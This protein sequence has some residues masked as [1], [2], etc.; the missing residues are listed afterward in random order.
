[1][2]SSSHSIA[3]KDHEHKW[4]VKRPRL[5]EAGKSTMTTRVGSRSS[6][7]TSSIALAP[8]SALDY[9]SNPCVAHL[10]IEFLTTRELGRWLIQTNK[11]MT[12]QVF[13][14]NDHWRILC[15][16]R[17]EQDRAALAKIRQYTGLSDEAIFRSFAYSFS[18]KGI[19]QQDA[20]LTL[21]Y[22]PLPLPPLQYTPNDYVVII[23]VRHD[24][25]K[26]DKLI[27]SLVLPG[28][29][30]TEIFRDGE[31]HLHGP[32][33]PVFWT[34]FAAR[35]EHD[36][37]GERVYDYPHSLPPYKV[38]IN[39]WRKGNQYIELFHLSDCVPQCFHYWEITDGKVSDA[40]AEVCG[41]ETTF[42]VQ[43]TFPPISESIE[44]RVPRLRVH[45]GA[46]FFVACLLLDVHYPAD[47]WTKKSST[48][49]A[50]V[51][52]TK[53]GISGSS[54]GIHLDQVFSDQESDESGD[55]GETVAFAH[56]LEAMDWQN[57]HQCPD[58]TLFLAE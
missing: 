41:Y 18:E 21:P 17:W 44:Q 39:L 15:E 5:E 33:E 46:N 27:F 20:P 12:A 22:L 53:I 1:M 42:S 3:R 36:S 49:D 6:S 4:N 2:D 40:Y 35:Q 16:S 34:N 28:T 57:I 56:L 52:I 32:D 45:D 54:N 38:K 29:D 10:L 48:T 24:N 26:D 43:H 47:G 14:G 13:S 19:E 9:L 25:N 50:A 11:A 23:D 58:Q 37:E 30:I 31:T 55:T 8:A 7:S 51:H